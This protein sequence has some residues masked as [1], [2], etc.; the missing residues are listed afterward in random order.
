MR[1]SDSFLVIYARKLVYLD[2]PEGFFVTEQERKVCRL[3]KALYGLKQAPR[4]RH[5]KLILSLCLFYQNW[6]GE[7]HLRPVIW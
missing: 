5:I 2:Q 6:V 7:M 1:L 4:S 3:V